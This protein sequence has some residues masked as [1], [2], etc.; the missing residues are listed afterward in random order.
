MKLW[1]DLETYS[2]TLITDG[3]HRYAEK[4]EVLLFAWAIDDS[5]VQCWDCTID[6]QNIPENL[7][8]GLNNAD[9]YWG[10]N[11]GGFD[12]TII[13]SCYR[14]PVY[15]AEH[16]HRDTMVQALCHGLPG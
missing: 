15:M 14:L 1:W 3:A 8:F 16:K 13:N 12:R 9:E 2:E 7:C 11:S 5:P 4:A 10:H 6:S